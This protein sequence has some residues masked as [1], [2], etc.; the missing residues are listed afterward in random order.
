MGTGGLDKR[1]SGTRRGQPIPAWIGFRGHPS[2]RRA[3]ARVVAKEVARAWKD[4]SEY[5]WVFPCGATLYLPCGPAGAMGPQS[6]RYRVIFGELVWLLNSDGDR[7]GNWRLAEKFNLGWPAFTEVVISAIVQDRNAGW[8]RAWAEY[9]R[10]LARRR[11]G[12]SKARQLPDYP[13]AK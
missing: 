1:N 9:W 5:R 10:R 4:T 3:F 2:I 6:L 11:L 8:H 7:D 13:R 12:A